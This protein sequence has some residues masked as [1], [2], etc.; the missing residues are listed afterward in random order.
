MSTGDGLLI[1]LSPVSGG[2]SPKQLIGLCE[3]AARHGNGIVEVTARGSCQFRG[4]STM[5]ASRFAEDVD[6]LAIDVRTGAPVEISPLAGMDPEEIGDSV[7][8]ARRIGE[9]IDALGLTDRLGPKVSVVVDGR[10]QVS[11]DDIV[12]DVRLT[13]GKCDGHMLW[14]VALAGDSGTAK[15]LGS[16]QEDG[17]IEAALTVLTKIAMQGQ[18]ARARDVADD[19]ALNQ[20]RST[21]PPSVLPDI[22]STRGEIGSFAQVASP[23]PK[24]CESRAAGSISP[25]VGE[26]SGRT[27]GGNIEHKHRKPPLPDFYRLREGG[28]T[29]PIS[30][31][32]GHIDAARLINLARHAE[33]LGIAD[34]RPAPARTLLPICPSLEAAQ[35]LRKHAAKLGFVT[36]AVDPRRSIAACPGA[37][38]CASGKIAARAIAEEV[39][40]SLPPGAQNLSIHISGCEKGCARQA[41]AD[42]TIVGGENGAGLVVHGTTR[43]RPLAYRSAA[44]LAEAIAAAATKL[45]AERRTGSAKVVDGTTAALSP[46]QS[47]CLK[48]AFEQDRP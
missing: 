41:A 5:S 36:D 35:A 48:A 21:L 46:A 39:A 47:A 31:P 26:M 33:A 42:I 7:A 27:E 14:R 40:R 32:F 16:Y 38:A 23:A 44:G 25:L 1:R 12:A 37:P 13:A 22:S 34:I 4:F 29:L 28:Y 18:G 30:L 15:L 24:V 9:G 20:L 10:G 43:A 8:L 6:A 45:H 2:F 19:R 11:R 3:S 17:A